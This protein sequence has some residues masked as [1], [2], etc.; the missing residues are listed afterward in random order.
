VVVELAAQAIGPLHDRT[1]L[2]IGAGKISS[3]TARSLVRA[4]LRWIL[5]AN[6]TYE[7]AQELAI[8]LNGS[9]VRFDALEASLKQADVVI[10]STGAPHTVLHADTV[11]KAQEAR[12]GRPLLIADL[13]VPRD[14]DPGI[15][16]IPGVRLI[17][18]DDLDR[19]A[20][21]DH[22]PTAPVC[23]E[24]RSIVGQ[25]L[26]FS[27]WC[28]ARRCASVI[29]AL[30]LNAGSICRPKCGT[31]C[32]GWGADAP[33][34]ANDPS[35]GQ[36]DYR[37]ITPRADGRLRELPRTEDAVSY[38]RIIRTCTASMRRPPPVRRIQS[39]SKTKASR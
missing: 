21:T 7:R 14:V 34:G 28:N 17:N 19:R 15:A 30:H 36:G 22:C 25:K 39:I 2:L 33:S 20:K 38:I 5:I 26:I 3:I 10:C 4:G 24:V 29:Q 12:G 1:A 8:H 16:S 18:V 6:R 9:A 23:R 37:K 32:G 11:R 31:P 13:A 35:H 27:G